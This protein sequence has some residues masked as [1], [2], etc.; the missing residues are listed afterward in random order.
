MRNLITIICLLLTTTTNAQTDTTRVYKQVDVKPEP[1]DL[2][3]YLRENLRYPREARKKEIEGKV[4][5][6]FIVN[7]DGTVSDVTVLKCIGGG[8]D[9]AAMRVIKYMPRWKPGTKDGKPVKVYFTLPIHFKL[10]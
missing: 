7:E 4:I 6:K 5:V 8:C 3:S 9:E 10:D 2:Q 1:W